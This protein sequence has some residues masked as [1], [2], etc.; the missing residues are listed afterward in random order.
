MF[1]WFY[2]DDVIKLNKFRSDPVN[3]K[4][5]KSR[6][7]EML[8]LATVAVFETLETRFQWT[9][10]SDT[11]DNMGRSHNPSKLKWFVW[12]RRLKTIQNMTGNKT[13]CSGWG[14]QDETGKYNMTFHN[15]WILLLQRSSPSK[16]LRK[17]LNK[18]TKNR[19]TKELV[20]CI[21]SYNGCSSLS[22]WRH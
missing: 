13:S 7:I 15:L 21:W 11:G 4:Y 14:I 3:W 6:V 1:W 12:M 19:S 22:N 9:C 20:T 16:H 18:Q 2:H 17:Y 5:L 8:L 10:V